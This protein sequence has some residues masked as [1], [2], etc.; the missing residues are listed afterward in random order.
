MGK[1]TFGRIKKSLAILLLVLFVTTLAASSVSAQP[2]ASASTSKYK[3]SFDS[4][5]SVDTSSSTQGPTKNILFT[6]D[7]GDNT[8][9][10]KTTSTIVTHTYDGNFGTH[11]VTLLVT[12]KT[13]GDTD[14]PNTIA[15][16]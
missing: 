10:H 9:P 11:S 12:D 5:Q 8:G 4:S 14:G 15:T 3:V 1:Q 13:T 2:T 16:V 7:F 6:W